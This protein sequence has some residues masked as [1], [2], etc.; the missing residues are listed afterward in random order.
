MDSDST[1]T[2]SQ[3][4]ADHFGTPPGGIQPVQEESVVTSAPTTPKPHVNPERDEEP[5]APEAPQPPHAEHAEEGAD[6]IE[7]PEE[8]NAESAALLGSLQGPIELE[9][10]EDGGARLRDTE[11]NPTATEVALAPV[12][13]LQAI[14]ELQDPQPRDPA[15]NAWLQSWR[16]MMHAVPPEQRIAIQDL[17]VAS[18]AVWRELVNNPTQGTTD[19]DFQSQGFMNSVAALQGAMTNLTQEAI[20]TIHRVSAAS[21]QLHNPDQLDALRQNV[22]PLLDSLLNTNLISFGS[23]VPQNDSTKCTVCLEDYAASDEIVVLPCHPTH[24]FHRTCIHDWL[25]TLVPGPPTCPN[26]RALIFQNQSNPH[27]Q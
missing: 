22:F 3:S 4:I 6:W 9:T 15:E 10:D 2:D 18:N 8:F 20:D 13:H 12:R 25:Q 23:D 16:Q 1:F 26:C 19:D 14:P 27:P 17:A 7:F 24:H 5:T 11:A 21:T